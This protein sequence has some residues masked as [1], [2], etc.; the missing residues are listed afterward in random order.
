SGLSHAVLCF[1][2]LLRERQRENRLITA[3]GDWFVI[4]ESRILQDVADLQEQFGAKWGKGLR[5]QKPG[6]LM[7][8]VVGEMKA[9][10]MMRGP[11][12]HGQYEVLPTAGRLA[13]HYADDDADRDDD[14]AQGAVFVDRI[15][16]GDLF[17][18]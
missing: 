14:D 7:E 18:E 8:D 5:E 16:S 3:G 17:E 6:S 13:A 11:D 1:C 12:A 2:G 4:H 10:G 9:W 15:V